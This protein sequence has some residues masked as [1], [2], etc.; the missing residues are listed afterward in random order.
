MYLFFIIL[1]ILLYNYF[2]NQIKD[3][4]SN[5][6]KIKTIHDI[7]I[8]YINLNRRKNTYNH[9]LKIA[10]ENE[11]IFNR[12]P[13]IDGT[14]LDDNI[15]IQKTKGRTGCFMSHYALWNIL[16]NSYDKNMILILEDDIK[17]C[18]NFKEKIQAVIDE[19]DQL[20]DVDCLMLGYNPYGYDKNIDITKHVQKTKNSFFGLQSY[21]VTNSGAQKLTKLCKVEQTAKPL[22]VLISEL[23][24]DNKLNVYNTKEKLIQLDGQFQSY[25]DTEL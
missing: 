17:L 10:Q 11:L 13:A 9:M 5:K 23:N 3:F 8:Y 25:S 12:F 14:N 6:K 4:F 21:I 20:K 24:Q 16:L 19:M 15:I 18:D 22:D 7:D 2:G 1:I